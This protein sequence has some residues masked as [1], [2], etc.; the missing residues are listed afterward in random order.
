MVPDVATE[1]SFHCTLRDLESCALWPI[2]FRR[3][4]AHLSTTKNP[5]V[6]RGRKFRKFLR[7]L[8]SKKFL[9]LPARDDRQP[10]VTETSLRKTIDF[11]YWSM[12]AVKYSIALCVYL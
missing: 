9:R 11:S 7:L 12:H 4:P 8:F 6:H 3:V 5:V 1:P 10:K 2:R